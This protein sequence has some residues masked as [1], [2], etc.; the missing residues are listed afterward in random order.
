M[1]TNYTV[2]IHKKEEIYVCLCPA[3]DVTSKRISIEEVKKNLKEASWS[4][5]LQEKSK[6][7][8]LV[9]TFMK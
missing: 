1:D 5:P 7:K 6:V 9:F 4:I 3:L 2:L 8:N